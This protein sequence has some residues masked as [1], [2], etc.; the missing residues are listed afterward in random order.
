M[1]EVAADMAFPAL[2]IVGLADTREQKQLDIEKL[3][4]AQQHDVGGL[5]PFGA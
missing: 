5:L 4:R 2:R 1:G 3:E